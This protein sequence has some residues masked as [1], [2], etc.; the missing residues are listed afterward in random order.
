MAAKQKGKKR[1]LMVF[2]DHIEV[3]SSRTGEYA[4]KFLPREVT[5]GHA[6]EVGVSANEAE[7]D[8]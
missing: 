2:D 5:G 1:K 7:E 4:L 6:Q 8:K 3:I